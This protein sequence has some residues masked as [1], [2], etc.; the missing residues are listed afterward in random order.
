MAE[1]EKQVEITDTT[2]STLTADDFKNY[3]MN[4][5]GEYIKKNYPEHIKTGF[6]N[7]DKLLGGGLSP[8]LTV[9]GAISSLGKSTFALQMAQNL[10]CQ[11]TCLIV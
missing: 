6:D 7:L 4:F 9:F 10:S 5:S 2:E 3:Q 11:K 1:S 8:C